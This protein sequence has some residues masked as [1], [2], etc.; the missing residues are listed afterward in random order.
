MA[1]PRELIGV[2]TSCADLRQTAPAPS[3]EVALGE[4]VTRARFE[5]SLQCDRTLVIR[6]LH[7]DIDIPRSARCRVRTTSVVVSCESRWDIRC[8]TGV[9]AARNPS[10]SLERRRCTWE[11]RLAGRAKQPPGPTWTMLPGV[12]YVSGDGRNS[13]DTGVN[14]RK[15]ILPRRRVAFGPPSLFAATVYNLRQKVGLPTEAPARLQGSEGWWPDRD[16]TGDL[17]NAIHAR[18]QLR[19]WP[20]WSGP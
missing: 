5:V 14:G 12:R 10:H 6:E 2:N 3:S 20:L 17:M 8:Q 16:R 13:R 19:Y 1:Q 9:I 11:S 4:G 15:Q 18:S 7:H